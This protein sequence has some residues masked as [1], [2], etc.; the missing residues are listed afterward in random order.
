TWNDFG[1]GTMI[2][3]TLSRGYQSLEIIQQKIGKRGNGE[4]PYGP[5]DLR[6]PVLLY[7]LKKK[8]ARNPAAMRDLA[9]ASALL[10]ADQCRTVRGILAKYI[11]Q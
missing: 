5:D 8:H 9:K 6:L 11:P 3:P 10:F 4:M 2:E 7:E 1:E